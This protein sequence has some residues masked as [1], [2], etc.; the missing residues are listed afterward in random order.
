MEYKLSRFIRP[1]DCDGRYFCYHIGLNGIF[2]VL[3]D[4]RQLFEGIVENKFVE[5][6]NEFYNLLVDEQVLVPRDLDENKQIIDL[7]D[8]YV[9]SNNT[10]RFVIMPTLDCNFSCRYCIQ[11]YNDQKTGLYLNRKYYDAIYKYIHNSNIEYIYIDWF[12]GEPLLSFDDIIYMHDKLKSISNNIITDYSLTTNGYLLTN[13]V[14]D[15]LIKYNI[16]SF[17]ITID[18]KKKLHDSMRYLKNGTGTFD[19]I[20]NNLI[21]LRNSD[22]NFKVEIRSNTDR[23][24]ELPEDRKDWYRF[25]YDQFCKDERFEFTEA[26]VFDGTMSKCDKKNIKDKETYL[27]SHFTTMTELGYHVNMLKYY[28]PTSGCTAA[29]KHTYIITPDAKLCKCASILDAEEYNILGKIEN[30]MFVIYDEIIDIW[31]KNYL[32]TDKHCLEC[33][34]APS[35]LG[36]SCP[37]QRMKNIKTRPCIMLKNELDEI[38]RIYSKR[39]MK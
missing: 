12:G 9:N 25:V 21:N 14:V 20:Y 10:L 36:M 5:A 15:A 13:D 39:S 19:T 17:Y 3:D 31:A 8:T 6:N 35:C 18:G 32:Q 2:R 23:S 24:S 11:E 28:A 16:K 26:F 33:Y 30:N 7:S 38:I 1:V 22:K 27:M 37:V 34:F 4:N 29:T